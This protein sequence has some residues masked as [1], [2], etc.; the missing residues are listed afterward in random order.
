MKIKFV[1]SFAPIVTD[2]AA[3]KKLYLKALGLPLKGKYP[4]T[5]KLKGVKHFGL[6]SLSEA[7]Q[8]CFRTEQWPNDIPRPQ[9][10]IEFDVKDAKSVIAA[11]RELKKKGYRLLHDAKQ[12]PWGQTV[13]RLLSPEGLIVGV[14]YTPSMHGKNS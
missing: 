9:A 10:S 12:E 2:M 6:W 3:S 8:T 11:A 14:S 13:A 4:H 7:A 5:E 1:A